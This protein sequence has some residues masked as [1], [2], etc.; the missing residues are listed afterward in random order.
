MNR[1]SLCALALLSLAT[2]VGCGANFDPGNEIKSLRVLG[3]KKDKPY[4]QPGDD[5]KLQLLWDDAKGRTEVQRVFVGGCINPPGDLYYGCFA[6]YGQ[7]F[8]DGTLP[9][10]G[11]GDSYQVTLPQDIISGRGGTFQPGQPHYGLYIVFFAVCAGTVDFA[12]DASAQPDGSTGLPIRCLDASG[13]PLGSDDFVVGYSSIYSFDGV[14]NENPSFS[15]DADGSV[16]FQVADAAVPSDCVGEACQGAAAVS[17][18]C[19]AT[20]ERCI[21]ACADDGDPSCPTIDV[22]P[23]IAEK[24]EKDQVSSD[25]FKSNVTEQMW[26]NYYV[27]HGSMSEVRLVNDSNSGWNP[28]YRGQLHAPKAPGPLQIWAVV[29]DNRG[30]M[31]FSRVTLQVQ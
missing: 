7:K 25:L 20:P 18:D 2:T 12:T 21:Q 24:V 23:A 17:V 10:P 16:P 1:A 6:Q 29:H 9:P 27:D 30:G 22:A 28:L 11:M 26:V 15:V 4:A 5:V 19:D 3:V 31:D 8:A 14:S 13:R